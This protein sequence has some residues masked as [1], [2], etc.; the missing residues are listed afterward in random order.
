MNFSVTEIS[1]S[2]VEFVGY[3]PVAQ[4]D[5]HSFANRGIDRL[6]VVFAFLSCSYFE[7]L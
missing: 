2:K 1:V 7:L 3:G 4:I 6:I 5:N